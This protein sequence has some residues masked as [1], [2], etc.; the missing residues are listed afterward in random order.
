MAVSENWMSTMDVATYKFTLYLVKPSLW[1]DPRPLAHDADAYANGIIISESGVTGGYGIDNVLMRTVITGS[2]KSGSVATGMMQFDLHEPL[3]F[4]LVDRILSF[5]KAFGFNSFASARYVMKIEFLGRNPKTNRVERYP[6]VHLYSLNTQTVTATVTE[7]GT[8]Y[9]FVMA[10]KSSV[11][12]QETTLAQTLTVKKITKTADLASQMTTTLNSVYVP[13]VRRSK[14]FPFNM[15]IPEYK[16]VFH[17]QGDTTYLPS[18]AEVKGLPGNV[19][20]GLWAR[21]TSNKAAQHAVAPDNLGEIHEEF[22]PGTN[23]VTDIAQR[24]TN[25]SEDFAK[26]QEAY[27]K[28]NP[29]KPTP[30]I[31]VV[32]VVKYKDVRDVQTGEPKLEIALVIILQDSNKPLPQTPDDHLVFLQNRALQRK[33]FKNANIKKKYAYLYS[34]ENTEVMNFNITFD[35]SILGARYPTDG[36]LHAPGTQM[37]HPTNPEDDSG[38]TPSPA[39]ANTGIGGTPMGYIEDIE[40]RTGSYVELINFKFD[41]I[42]P[43][44]HTLTQDAHP[45]TVRALIDA[46]RV[47]EMAN[48]EANGLMAEIEIRG[49]PFW[50]GAPGADLS[51]ATSGFT[52]FES[53]ETA[54]ISKAAEVSMHPY[55]YKGDMLIALATYHPDDEIAKPGGNFNKQMDMISSGVYIVNV[56]EHKFNNGMFTQTLHCAR[57]RNIA[58]G[59]VYDLLDKL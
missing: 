30:V 58:T 50:L 3:G 46:E 14:D 55:Q 45:E 5:T 35:T 1:N 36:R 43:A 15:G 17:K 32:P 13:S 57:E 42:N 48:R 6:G 28:A 33:R 31:K 38:Q 24:I 47:D 41:L 11:A 8:T 9:N 21:V 29:D 53:M 49:D 26:W 18:G 20:D 52:R 4:K 2:R 54:V 19:I 40:P 56:I 7:R 23:L 10:T 39:K 37:R 44:V 16:V 12:A 22:A 27:I 34:G 59:M 25:N 51:G